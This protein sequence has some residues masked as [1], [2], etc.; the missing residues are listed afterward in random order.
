MFSTTLTTAEKDACRAY[1]NARSSILNAAHVAYTYAVDR[2]QHEADGVDAVHHGQDG[3]E[4]WSR[5][6]FRHSHKLRLLV[7]AIVAIVGI[8]VGPVVSV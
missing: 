3:V 2:F 6:F 8:H 7:L 5:A 1:R 4:R